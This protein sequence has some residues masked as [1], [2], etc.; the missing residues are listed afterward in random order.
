MTFCKGAFRPFKKMVLLKMQWFHLEP[1]I[2][3]THTTISCLNGCLH[4]TMVLQND[5]E[6]AAYVSLQNFQE[7]GSI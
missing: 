6:W 5:G 1:W 7:N 4:G 3:Y 2:L